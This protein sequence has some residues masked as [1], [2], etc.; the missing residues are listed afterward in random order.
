MERHRYPS[1]PRNNMAVTFLGTTSGGGPT[2]TR[3][4]SSLVVG[5]MGN[6]EL[7]MVDCAEG[8]VRQFSTQPH[9]D[10]RRVKINDVTKMFITHMHADHTMGIIT[11]LRNVLGMYRGDSHE[12]PVVPRPVRTPKIEI[13]GPRGIRHF[14]R[15]IFTLTHTR[16]ADRYCVHELLM[17]GETASASANDAEQLH[18]SEEAGTDIPC[19]EDGFWRGVVSHKLHRGGAN[20][21]VVDAG[22]IVHRDPCIGYIIREKLNLYPNVERNEAPYTLKPRMIV[23]LGDTSDPTALIPLVTEDPD[24]PVSLLIHEATDA[25]IPPSVDPDQRTGKNRSEQSVMQKAVEKG[26]STPAMAGLFARQ[27]SAE[28]LA[29][30]HIGSRFPAP[31][32]APKSFRDKFRRDCMAEVEAQATRTW[33][34]ENGASA[35]AVSDFDRIIIPPNPL[36][37]V[38]AQESEAEENAEHGEDAGQSPSTSAG[39]DVERSQ[40]HHS[41]DPAEQGKPRS[42]GGFQGRDKSRGAGKKREHSGCTSR[43]GHDT[44]R[45]DGRRQHPNHKK[46]RRHDDGA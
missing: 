6:N 30:N 10:A 29:L 43:R 39:T 32:H 4:C 1:H 8:T 42:R 12:G 23:A 22:P 33:N 41:S 13:Y 37:P 31:P 16:S 9:R 3:N 27:I 17:H 14:I 11:L 40:A 2:D 28:R 19:G 35:M 5:A 25:Y 21:L 34:P 36:V 20:R 24:A 7:W 18:P 45:G 46:Q 38:G 26:H 44:G 15:T